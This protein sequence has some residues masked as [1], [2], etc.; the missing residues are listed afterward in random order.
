[1]SQAA[2]PDKGAGAVVLASGSSYPDALVG[3]PLA[4]AK[5][6]PILLT[7]GATLPDVTLAELTRVLP[8]GGTVYLLGGTTA[9]PASVATQLTSL[10]Y[11]VTRIAGADR[12]RTAVAI[13]DTLGDPTTV[14]LASGNGFADALVAGPAASHIGGVVLLTDGDAMAAATSNYLAAHPGNVFAIGGPAATARQD[15]TR[16]AGADRYDTAAK[17]ANAFFTAPPTATVASGLSFADALR[18][19]GAMDGPLLLTNLA[20]LSAP[21]TTYLSSMRTSLSMVTVVGGT[22]ALPDST[23]DAIKGSLGQ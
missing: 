12:Y 1:M 2:F 18:G 9:I 8:A 19:K 10:G 6:A 15:A 7:A 13:A 11:T 16:V 21:A 5:N 14:L 23:L 3:V 4:S 20:G 22:A 17:V